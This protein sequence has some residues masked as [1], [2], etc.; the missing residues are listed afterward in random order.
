[1]SSSDGMLDAY[2][3]AQ[4][5]GW[6]WDFGTMIIL[7]YILPIGIVILILGVICGMGGFSEKRY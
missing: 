5:L 6:N 7:G 4:A 1:M 3:I 2:L